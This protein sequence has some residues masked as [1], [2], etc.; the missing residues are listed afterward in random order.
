MLHLVF[1]MTA[2]NQNNGQNHKKII[3]IKLTKPNLGLRTR[4]TAKTT[5]NNS[6]KTIKTKSRVKNQNN[7]QHRK[8]NNNHKTIKT[9]SRVKNQNNSQDHKKIIAIISLIII[10]KLSSVSQILI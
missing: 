5:K 2:K 3:A 7:S 9:K 4:I 6:H 8:K 1:A 10:R